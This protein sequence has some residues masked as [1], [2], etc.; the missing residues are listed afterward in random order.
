[1]MHLRM[2]LLNF[3]SELELR[4]DRVRYF[5]NESNKGACETRNLGIFNAKGKFI[6]GLDD[7]DEFTPNR[8]SFF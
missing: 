3:S 7:D 5:R 4:D 8:L 2:V 1:M 6:T